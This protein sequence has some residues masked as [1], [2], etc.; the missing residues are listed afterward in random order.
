MRRCFTTRHVLTAFILPE[1][2]DRNEIYETTRYYR[3]SRNFILKHLEKFDGLW[4]K[5]LV[6]YYNFDE[7]FLSKNIKKFKKDDLELYLK[8]IY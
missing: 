5:K 2:L 7:P 8:N 6:R 3:L 4:T 1:Y